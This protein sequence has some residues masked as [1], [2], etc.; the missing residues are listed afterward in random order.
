MPYLGNLSSPTK[1]P[2]GRSEDRGVGLEK[3][4]DLPHRAFISH[5][6]DNAM[7]CACTA[8]EDGGMHKS[9][10]AMRSGDPSPASFER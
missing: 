9:S 6:A 10:V 7:I 3:I 2:G 4:I 8:N 1:G 5:K